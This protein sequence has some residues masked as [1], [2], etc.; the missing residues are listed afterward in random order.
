MADKL[1]EVRD[2]CVA[3]HVQ[4]NVLTPIVKKV[5]FSIE[6]GK[7]VALIGESGSG[8]TTISL[9]CMGYA[10][11]GCTITGG[12]VKLDD[13]EVLKLGFLERRR[14]RGTDVSY[15]AQSA[16]ASFNAA[17]T[18][19]RQV[20]ETP[21]I[22][23]LMSA[24]EAME[25]AVSLYHE[26]DLPEPEAIGRR[27]PHQVSGGQLQ[28][29]MAAM[30]M[31]CDP[32]LLI[33]DEPTTALDVTTQIEV[34]QA[35]KKLIRDKHTSA[36]YVSHDL[37]VV[38]QVA[39]DILVL[40]DGVMIEYGPAEQI[41]NEP[42]QD[43]TRELISAAH[44]MPKSM[45]KPR[46]LIIQTAQNATAQP[47]LVVD[48]VTAG[49]GQNHQYL[50]LHS[51]SVEAHVG[52][53]IGIIGESGSGK[54]TL[55]RVISGLMGS[56]QGEVRLDGIPLADSIA[57]R[58][59]AELRSVQFAFQMADVALNPRHRIRKILGRPLK[60][61]FNMSEG[62]V[63]HR[64]DE[65]LDT[66]EL[67]SYFAN[68]FPRELSG[69]ERQRIN[70]ARSLTA[71]P[72]LIICDEITSALDTIVAEAILKL[73]R[74]L[75]ERLKVAYVFISHDLSTIAKVADTI[76]VMRRGKIVEYGSTVE[77]LTPPHHRYTELLLSS[78]PDLR[79]DWLDT[80]ETRRAAAR[81]AAAG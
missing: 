71:E 33:L 35:F 28:R 17:L 62:E 48:G 40:K 45:P 15:V 74:E 46:S 55:G 32:K 38:A 42:S 8:K 59:R 66:V 23:N 47:L 78:V 60:F 80:I 49:Y 26:L 25:K 72:K 10:R 6:T 57:R 30:A 34:L 19:T 39:D 16:A 52:R 5:S 11:P 76:A 69:G 51:V 24:N 43:Y 44:I 36:I 12:G 41:I 77:I 79:T 37:A 54:T 21:L 73:L 20:I 75:Q 31:I 13:I 27:Y 63:G 70:L 7:V 58:S 64:V 53:T 1:L 61:Y 65:I 2:L 67:P 18:I 9:A 3:A 4:K 50:A 68:R 14:F 56:K 81:I 22:K 29:L